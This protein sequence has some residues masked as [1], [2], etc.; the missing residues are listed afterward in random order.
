[1]LWK[2]RIS[3]PQPYPNTYNVMGWESDHKEHISEA[4]ATFLPCLPFP[5]LLMLKHS[6]SISEFS[7]ILSV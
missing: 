5:Y 6:N 3:I 7:Y 4:A 2:C 1:M